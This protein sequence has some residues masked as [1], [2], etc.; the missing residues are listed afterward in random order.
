[1]PQVREERSKQLAF[2]EEPMS[3]LPRRSVDN[4][5]EYLP[6]SIN[7]TLPSGWCITY[8]KSMMGRKVTL[9]HLLARVLQLKMKPNIRSPISHIP[10][11]RRIS[12]RAKQ[13]WLAFFGLWMLYMFPTRK[14]LQLQNRTQPGQPTGIL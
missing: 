11:S 2:R 3:R 6:N 7:S 12:H 4:Q 1:M 8:P 14:I 5:G 9:T 10:Q 13:Q